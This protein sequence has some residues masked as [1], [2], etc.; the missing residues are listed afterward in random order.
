ME[1]IYAQILADHVADV[2]HRTSGLIPAGTTVTSRPTAPPFYELAVRIDFK[3]A[4]ADNEKV[5]GFVICGSVEREESGPLLTAIARH[6][7][8]DES[9][10]DTPDG[11]VNILSEFLNIVIGLTGADWAEHG[12]E[13]NFSTPKNL[14]GQASPVIAETE[15]AFHIAV[16]TDIGA[17][18]ELLAVFRA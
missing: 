9:L 10:A 3:G 6:L 5:S 15:T 13:M 12:F 1:K 16:T 2:I 18:V 14:S 7:G 8:F 11:P 4:L 17:T